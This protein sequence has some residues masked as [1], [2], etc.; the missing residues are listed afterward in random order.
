MI[1]L[2]EPEDKESRVSGF[3]KR[4][5]GLHHLCYEVPALEPEIE[6]SLASGAILVAE[7]AAAVAFQGRR[8]AWICTPDRLLIEYLERDRQARRQCNISTVA[9]S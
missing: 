9:V 7:A 4:G 6:R 2:I 1:E 3:L 8:I 5:G